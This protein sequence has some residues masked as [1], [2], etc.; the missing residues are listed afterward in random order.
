MERLNASANET[1]TGQPSAAED[2]ASNPVELAWLNGARGHHAAPA[3]ARAI[4]R[5]EPSPDGVVTLPP[6]VSLEAIH[7]VGRDLV[8]QLPD[9]TQMIIVD[10]AIFVPQLVI[11]GVEI[12]PVNLAAL[13]IGEEPQP[14]AGSPQSSGGNFAIPVGNIGDGLGLGDL[15]PPTALQFTAPEFRE[16]FPAITN[17]EPDILIITPEAPGGL[18]D[19]TTGVAEAGLPARGNEPPGSNAA[20]N[21]ETTIGSIVFNPGDAPAV[22]TINGTAVTA[23]GQTITGTSGTLTITSI[24]DGTIG[25]SYTL[26]DNSSGDTTTDRFAVVVTDSDGDAAQG[27]LTVNI[28]DD[29]PTARPDTDAIPAGTYGPAV[30]NVIDATGTTSGA[31]GID[32][33]GADGASLSGIRLGA[34][35]AFTS[36]GVAGATINGQYGVLTITPG[37]AYSYVRNPG[38]SG[39]VTDSFT[40]QLSDGDGDTSTATLSIAIGDSGTVTTTP[41]SG[42]GTIVNEAGLPARGNEPPGSASATPVE[43]TSGTIT[44]NAPDG[45]AT[46]TINGV[47]VTTVGQTITTQTG[48]LTVTS[49]ADGAIGYNYTLTDNT[50]G[51]TATDTFTVVVTDVD[52]DSSTAPL[53]ITIIDDVPLAVNDTAAQG[54]ENQPVVINAFANDVFGA[55]GVDTDN[56][57]AV[58]VTFT[59]TANGSV[60]Y[61]AATGL[62]TFTPAPGQQGSDSF[63]YTITDGD[64]DSS[65]ATVTVSLVADSI[66]TVSVTDASVSEAGLPAGSNAASNSETATGTFA[67]ATAGDSLASLVINGVNVTNGGTVTGASGTLTVALAGGSYSYSYTLTNNTSGD[68]TTDQFQ[69]VATDSDGDAASDTLTINIVDDVPTAIADV[70]GVTEDGPLVAD[71]NVLSGAGG[72]DAN[73]SDGVADIKGADGASVTAVS[74]G[75]TDGTIGSGLPGAYGTLTL[76]ADGAYA[77]SLDNGSQFVQGLSAGQTLTET[78]GYTI[79]DGDGDI[80]STTLTITITGADDGVTITGLGGAGAEETVFEND[81]ADGTSPD[82][83]ALT[84]TGTFSISTVDGLGNVTVGGT[85]VVN[86]G[87]F[88]PGLSATSATGAVTITGFTP[89][90]GAD[91]STIGGTFS[92]SYTLADN[93]LAHSASGADGVL[94]SFAVLVTDS[95]GSSA[96]ASLDIQIIDDLPLANADANNVVEGDVLTI[97]AGAGVLAND[98]PGADGF[99]AGGGVVGVRAA[100]ADTNTAVTSGLNSAITGLYGTL[101]LQADGSYSYASTPNAVPPGGAQDVFVYTVRDGD[102]DQST[103]TLT[104]N[105]A[106]SGLAASNED[107][108]VNEAALPIGSNPASTAET[109]TGTLAD[110]VSNGSAPYSF[111]LV[112]GG[113]GT[114]GTLSLNPNGTYSYTLATPFDTTPSANNGANIE[115]NAETFT[116]QVT[117]ADGNVTTSTLTVDIVDDVPS[118]TV[119]GAIP[120]LTVDETVLATD[121]SA[122]FASVFTPVFGADG[123]GSTSYALGVVAGA[124]GLADIATGEAVN[125]SL[126]GGVVEGRTATTNL[127]VFSVAADAANGSV[128]LDQVRAVTHTPDTGPD[129]S[130]GLA[131]ANLVTLTATIVDGDGDSASATANIGGA[132]SF[133]DDAPAIDAAVVDANTV[134]LTTQDAETIGAASDTAIST[135]NFGGAFSVASSSYGADGAGTTAWN[136]ALSVTSAASGLTSNGAA[137]SLYLVGGAVIGSTAANA[138]AVTAS[139]SIFSLAVAASTGVVTL[140]QFAE[141]DHAPN[142]DTAAPYDDQFAILANGLVSLDGTA[143]ITDRD[144]D[145]SSDTVSLDLGG[146]VRFADDG[147]SIDASVT[148]ANTLL[149]TTQDAQTIGGASD[150]DVSTANFGSAFS[151]ATSSYGADGAGTTAW[152]YALGVSNA[153][154]GLAS[155]GAAISLYLIGGVVVGSTSATQ[156]GVTAGNTIF[157]LSVAA[158]TGVVTLTQFAEIDHA[159]NGDTS[160]PYDDQFAILANGL[161]TLSGTATITDGDGDQA[162]ETVVL[163]L[164]GNVRFADDGPSV[165]ANGAIPSLT[166][167]ETVLATNDSASFASIFAPVFGADGP[168][169]TSYA[170]SVVAGASGLVDTLTN[171]AVNL[172]LNGGVV[173]GRTATTNLLV[174]TASVNASGQVTLDQVRAVVHSPDTGPDQSTGLASADLVKLTATVTDGDGDSASAVANI[175]GALH[176]E[177]DAPSASPNSGSVNEGALLTVAA[178]S[179]V[180]T[181]DSA[182][183]DGYAAGGG[184]VGVRAAGGDT[185]TAVTTGTGNVIAGLY[186]TLTLQA[187]GGYS[188]QS[189]ANAI[190]GNVSD[191]FVYTIRDGD[192]DQATTTLTI[193]LTDSGL[194]ATPDDEVLV[195]EKALDT[196][197]TGSDLAAGT[198]TGSLPGDAGETDASNTLVGNVSGGFGALSYSLVGSAVG[199]YGTIQINSNGTYVYTLTK[200]YDTSPDADNS[201][202]TEQNRDSFTYRATDANGNS[203]TSTIVVDIVDDVPTASN[204]ASQN[205]AEGATVTGT[206][207]FVKGADGATVTHLNG[208]ALAFGADG[209]SQAIDIGPGLLKVKADGSYSFTADA[210]TVS[211]VPLATA[212]YTVTDGDGDKSTANISFQITDANLPSGGTTAASVDDDGLAGGNSANTSGDLAVPNTDGDNNEATFAGTLA[213]GFGLDGAGSV[214][215]ASMNGTSGTVGQETVN[216]SWSGSTLTATGPRGVLFTVQVTDPA[217]GA[218]KVTLVDNVLHDTLNGAAGDNTE[219]DATA[220]LTYTILD[221]DGSSTTGTLNVTFDDDAPTVNSSGNITLTGNNL[222]G[223]AAFSYAIG[224]DSRTAFSAPNSDLAV[225]LSGTVGTSA[226]VSPVVTWAS[227]TA[228]SATFNF[229][230]QY[231]PDPTSASNPLTS[232]TGSIVF[233]K[234]AGTYTVTLDQPIATFS[235]ATTSSTISSTG[236]DLAGSPQPEVVVS[237]LSNSPPLYVQFSGFEATG[238]G[239]GVPLTAGGNTAFAAG[240]TFSA[241]QAFVS[242][243]GS[244]NGVASDTIQRGEVL[245]FDFFT[246]NP[247]SNTSLAPSAAAT[248][249]FLKIDGFGSEDLVVILKLADPNNPGTVLTT[250]AIIVDAGDVYTQGSGVPTGYNVS[251]DSNDGLIVI[252]S[253]DYNGVGENYVIVGAQLL[254]STE[255]I[256]GSGINLN[257]VTGAAG[258]S[259]GTQSFGAATTDT[260]VIKISDIGLTRVTT[261]TQTV[262]LDFDVTVTDADGDSTNVTRLSVNPLTPPIAIDL[263]GNGLQFVDQ[264]AGVLFDYNGDG[265]KESTAWVANHDGL[266]AVDRN[267]DG[268]VNDGSEIVFATSANGAATDLEGL[269]IDYDSNHDGVLS[270]ADADFAKFGV[271]Q[272][273][274]GNG[275]TD[276][277]EFKSLADLGIVSLD[278]NSD[279]KSYT[280][281]NDQV[282]VFG[283]ATYTRADGSEG[284]LG[285]VAFATKSLDESQKLAA[286]AATSSGLSMIAASLV[287]AV[288]AT[289]DPALSIASAPISDQAVSAIDTPQLTIEAADDGV[290]A[291]PKG[292]TSEPVSNSP[293][294][295][296]TSHLGGSEPVSGSSLANSDTTST[297]GADDT[298]TLL[299]DTQQADAGHDAPATF[300]DM[301]AMP[302]LIAASVEAPAPGVAADHTGQVAAVLADALA[303]GASA[304]PDISALLASLPTAEA[305]T[306]VLLDAQA[307]VPV[308]MASGGEYHFDMAGLAHDAVTATVHA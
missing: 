300:L 178:A 68:A 97:G 228:T 218:Y 172:S 184:V 87:V 283:E 100:G 36:V 287:A 296:E 268:I 173:E 72:T 120:A 132:L 245:D 185:T 191:V 39:G 193:N 190:S 169:T 266:L 50:A 274:N 304:G 130:T 286:Q 211:P 93:T 52:G 186:G 291:A 5:V 62:F 61:D 139:N 80:S 56:S 163:D 192:G 70:D 81:L 259:S 236:Y 85:L 261:S 17:N 115:N 84:Q 25:Y 269:R 201:T 230:F 155:N 113:T 271:W 128:T 165:T 214:N 59:Q 246:S 131:A 99:A 212:T 162:S 114:H 180:L 243:S 174:F 187:N 276:A 141:I 290:Q 76:G 298:S 104:I 24:V 204:E 196:S 275:V 11:G 146:N 153:A 48:I 281:A 13:L 41:S 38:T 242:I 267:G 43:M 90:I 282:T 105:L 158:S 280:A 129:Q 203:V 308:W 79:T 88:T 289:A 263:D 118:V 1:A 175:G 69:V 249:M 194:V 270:A 307:A 140:T 157:N 224:A 4:V 45:P 167:D 241:A 133:E 35:G 161:V 303:G 164:G 288:D 29:V 252:E 53:T 111:A 107:V 19:A 295:A 301:S 136:Y 238:G 40:Y 168:G 226:I 106:D 299:A 297:S 89:V 116:Y 284:R 152:N 127:L 240:E 239:G 22:V 237:L 126:N 2:S 67:I 209:Y 33:P 58:A 217:T 159:P 294:P 37:G 151:I 138:G 250:R 197:V 119:T 47:A 227:E 305:A 44:Y 255:G 75:A 302:A 258:G 109:V 101:T 160:A 8:V 143:T 83:P 26:T 63:T 122:S 103:T 6:G 205:V 135:A 96:T 71:G 10:G 285:D 117:D 16:L 27:T 110:N 213:F 86:N 46:V 98:I 32:T 145:P 108:S 253:N 34:T 23:V 260:D 225:A 215:F 278:L 91:G 60:S 273:A 279:G 147:P 134:L 195:Y 154:S 254:S 222:S 92:Y 231:D 74:F 216:Y 95:D 15:L 183:A 3:A 42:E 210:A 181:N 177:D 179:G 94:D 235:V 14:A 12:P 82:A 18:V 220:A 233:N 121:A 199:A 264:S 229:S 232:E 176:F 20:A 30:G 137:I 144:G 251:L 293:A 219:N 51:N 244:A 149:L 64:G 66:P 234:A 262:H 221:A 272:D 142:G 148:D 257:R 65:T 7:V 73:A 102:G 206:L 49:I 150:T 189:T 166:V 123:A 57:P 77:Y 54:V 207:D 208:T 78:F 170:L 124:S 306:P 247:G 21:S 125:L 188:Y 9:G 200:P 28:A 182:G 292:E 256:T 171:E 55:D 277:G 31:P 198:V 112:G 248:G 156:A 223:S 265:V 202:N